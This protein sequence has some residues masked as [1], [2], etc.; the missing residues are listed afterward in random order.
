MLAVT[1]SVYLRVLVFEGVMAKSKSVTDRFGSLFFSLAAF[2]PLV[3]L[4]FP[5][6]SRSVWYDIMDRFLQSTVSLRLQKQ[7]A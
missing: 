4:A 6:S 7:F 2:D 3:F 1:V 5:F